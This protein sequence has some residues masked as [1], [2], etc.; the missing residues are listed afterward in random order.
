MAINSLQWSGIL[1]HEHLTTY[2][3]EPSSEIVG[4]L[5]E[6]WV[7]DIGE[8]GSATY[9]WNIRKNVPF[10]KQ[11]GDWGTVTAADVVWSLEN[12]ATQ[13]SIHSRAGNLIREWFCTGCEVTVPDDHTIILKHPKVRASILDISAHPRGGDVTVHSK[14]HFDAVGID[15]ANTES[16][17][18]GPWILTADLDSQYRRVLAVTDHWRKVPNFAEMTW[19]EIAE[20]STRLAN[21]QAGLLD[22]GQ[23]NAESIQAI[24]NLNDPETKFLVA[25]GGLWHSLWFHGQ[26]YMFDHPA[27][28]GE[29]PRVP[30]ADTET[31]CQYAW[32][33]CDRDINSVEWEKA[34]M[35]R[36]AVNHAVDREALI[37][38]LAYGAGRALHTPY[39]T[40]Y[41]VRAAQF[42][43]D[44]LKYEYDPAK[45]RQLLKDAGYE[46]GE[47]E[48]VGAVVPVLRPAATLSSEAAYY[49]ISDLLPNMVIERH[50]WASFRPRLLNR[51]FKGLQSYATGPSFREPLGS[52]NLFFNPNI[53]IHFGMEHPVFDALRVAAG[54]ETDVEKR[55]VI[56]A[57]MLKFLHNEAIGVGLYQ[58]DSLYPLSK[59]LD[60][61]KRAS[62]FSQGMLSNWEYAPH[63]GESSGQQ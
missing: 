21:F 36:Q 61:W 17:G 28:N 46:G 22:T 51:S 24:K 42:G 15:Q 10:N 35:V 14:A 38:N 40:G 16:V 25:Y 13:G 58:E 11:H 1:T 32:I 49:M 27:H 3:D 48:I 63:R 20:E 55:W 30:M 31:Q 45:A 53:G 18:T 60:P 57:D 39:I 23:Y 9:T 2:A 26:D 41:D 56:I 44:K 33:S 34:R 29:T 12:A 43:I 50:A 19:W 5:A 62:P 8:D 59:K 7:L 47:F 4:R 52:M 54:G 37:N 6:S